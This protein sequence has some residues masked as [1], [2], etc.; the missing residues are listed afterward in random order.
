MAFK[1]AV[2]IL[3]LAV[4][5]SLASGLVF[6]IRDKGQSD[7]TVKSLTLRIVLSIA[8]FVLLFIG[9]AAGLIRPHGITPAPENRKAPPAQRLNGEPPADYSQ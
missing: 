6:L 7:R 5:V 1:I 3:L 9:F 2:V 4:L 8:L